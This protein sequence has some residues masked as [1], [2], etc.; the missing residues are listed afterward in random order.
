[1]SDIVY[2]LYFDEQP[3]TEEQL[4]RLLTITVTQEMDQ[5]W[6]AQIKCPLCLDEQGAWTEA[7]EAFVDSFGRVRIE[8][9][10][11]GDNWI[12]LIDGP[13]VG[14]DTN[15]Q[16][17]PGQSE[18]TILI[19]DDSVYLN[20]EAI[21]E[22]VGERSDD[23]IVEYLFSLATQISETEIESLPPRR[24]ELRREQTLSGMPIRIMRT[25]AR[26]YDKHVYVLPG[27][28]IG[29]SIGCFKAFPTEVDELLPEMVTIGADRN[30][31]QF[32]AQHN[33]QQP[34]T[35]VADSISLSDKGI[36][37]STSSFREADLLGSQDPYPDESETGNRRLSHYADE[38]M[39]LDQAVQS[40]SNRSLYA[41]TGQGSVI[42][43]CYQGVLA[44]YKMVMVKA[45]RTAL[46]GTYVITKVVH[47][48]GQEAYSQEFNVVRNATSD[49]QANDGGSEGSVSAAVNVS[50]SIV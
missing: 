48:L 17:A 19:H 7:D 1:M 40:Q 44:P 15:M 11:D 28:T 43:S 32:Q 23:E 3:A 21:E 10:V 12:P 18:L 45:G 49:A 8:I 35:Y 22:E 50:F 36:I 41:Y 4:D 9:R 14:R 33:A 34:A 25:L 2:R 39:D 27:E 26:Q 31:S 6:E 13:V 29:A 20:R 30:V 42:G 46:S 47:T 38:D 16:H 37:S 24:E 5:A